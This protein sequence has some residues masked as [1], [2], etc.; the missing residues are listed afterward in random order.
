M[1]VAPEGR[2]EAMA[3]EKF[4]EPLL[5]RTPSPLPYISRSGRWSL[6]KSA[7]STWPA[8]TSDDFDS[9]HPGCVVP[10]PEPEPAPVPPPAVPLPDP[11]PAVDPEPPVDP[12]EL[13]EPDPAPGCVEP[14]FEP[15][16]LPP[17]AG[18]SVVE[19]D[20]EAVLPQPLRIKEKIAQSAMKTAG[21]Q[22]MGP[23]TTV[24]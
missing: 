12:P 18:V 16:L 2:A 8:K 23:P 4:P 3:E 13:P 10:P 21:L 20:C 22:R 5:S 17:G 7:V 6:L 24:K 9:D 15:E 1:V 11:E 14:E 19:V